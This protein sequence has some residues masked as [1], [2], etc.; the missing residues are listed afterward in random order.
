MSGNSDARRRRRGIRAS[1]VTLLLCAVLFCAHAATA[2]GGPGL[3]ALWGG[4]G[5]VSENGQILASG[6][7]HWADIGRCDIAPAT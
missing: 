6:G 5:S 4:G 3:S 7:R 2:F 1:Q